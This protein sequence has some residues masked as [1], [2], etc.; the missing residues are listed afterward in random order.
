MFAPGTRLSVQCTQVALHP[1]TSQHT[2]E[3]K[4][5]SGYRGRV[6]DFVYISQGFGVPD[7]NDAPRSWNNGVS[8]VHIRKPLPRLASLLAHWTATL[9]PAQLLEVRRLAACIASQR[10]SDADRRP[11]GTVSGVA[12][13]GGRLKL[14]HGVQLFLRVLL[15][16]RLFPGKRSPMLLARALIVVCKARTS[17]ARG[18]ARNTVAESTPQHARRFVATSPPCRA[19][20]TDRRSHSSFLVSG[21]YTK[22]NCAVK[23]DRPLGDRRRHLLKGMATRAERLVAISDPARKARVQA[24]TGNRFTWG[25]NKEIQ[26]ASPGVLCDII[27]ELAVDFDAINLSCAFRNL[28]QAQHPGI[29]RGVVDR[30]LG[31][32]EQRSLESI[33]TFGHKEISGIL[34]MM[35]KKGY[36]PFDPRLLPALEGQLEVVTVAGNEDWQPPNRRLDSQT[37]ANVAWSF[38]KMGRIP[39]PRLMRALEERIWAI[40]ETFKPQEITNVLWSYATAGSTPGEGVVGALEGRLLALIE[41]CGPQ[42]LG[43]SMWALAKM[44]HMPAERV[45]KAVE[46]RLRV[47]IHLLKPQNVTNVIWAYG[48][49]KRVPGEGLM[50]LLLG[51]LRETLEMTI[52]QDITNILWAIA[53]LGLPLERGA[54]EMMAKRLVAL[55]RGVNQQEVANALWAHATLGLMPDRGLV[56]ALEERMRV[57]AG[58]CSPQHISNTLWAYAT[59]GLKPGGGLLQAMEARMR[60]VAEGGRGAPA[61]LPQEIANT[62]WAYAKMQHTPDRALVGVLER[63]MELAVQQG[64]HTQSISNYLWAHATLKITLGQPVMAA[65]ESRILAH[66]AALCTPRE[67]TNILWAYAA[68]GLRPSKDVVRALEERLWS[69]LL[70]CNPHDL[71]NTL[72]SFVKIQH[73]PG[74][75]LVAGLEGLMQAAGHSSVAECSCH[76][77]AYAGGGISGVSGEAAGEG[78]VEF[79]AVRNCQCALGLCHARGDAQRGC[80]GLARGTAPCGGR[81]TQPSGHLYDAVGGMLLVHWVA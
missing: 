80:R 67:V 33:E 45:I 16:D 42:E 18:R 44:R 68:S 28:L 65:L 11:R 54:A 79:Y 52:A 37:V 19:Y 9:L 10:C 12:L 13:C 72:W 57:I 76:D 60:V 75:G 15:Q 8:G 63:R 17:S 23:L 43:N 4:T 40:L 24:L 49:L 1:G 61:A 27:H 32:L 38:A 7:E 50:A 48:T 35:A 47:V 2:P 6:Y 36:T 51:R 62:M 5:D 69:V 34:H 59:L 73:V 74:Q 66:H 3:Q 14:E 81:A 26:D 21:H 53:T 77:G 25:V 64:C 46:G 30:A 71:T 22:K 20:S 41:E 39:G 29:A 56:A 58:G 55:S 70:E 31:T 78:G